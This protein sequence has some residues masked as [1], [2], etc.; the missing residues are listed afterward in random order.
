MPL[1]EPIAA[2]AIFAFALTAF[3]I[4]GSFA[5]EAAMFPRTVAVVM[6]VSASLY[7]VRSIRTA[8]IPIAIERAAVLRMVASIATSVAY[9]ALI[10]PLGFATASF[11]YLIA[12]VLVLGMRNYVAVLV[13]AILFVG[14]VH[15]VFERV[16]AT[17]LPDE[18]ISSFF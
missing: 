1:R 16:F 8:P 12:T 17:P 18:L 3:I 13:T 6:M 10:V 9:V 11:L 2:I 4:A 15:S 7:F 5:Q 14:F